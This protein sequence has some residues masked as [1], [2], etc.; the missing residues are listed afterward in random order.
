[1]RTI[2]FHIISQTARFSG[3]VTENKT[4][5]LIFSTT[6]VCNISLSRKSCRRYCHKS[7][8]LG[9]TGTRYFCR[10]LMKLQFSRQIC[11]KYSN[12]KFHE[13]SSSRS[14]VVPCERTDMTN[15]IGVFR[16]FAKAPRK[17]Q[18]VLQCNR[19]IFYL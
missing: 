5:V 7:T 8:I 9:F 15:L 4:R 17:Y 10:I 1:M 2:F 18:A 14:R 11:E 6:F 13:N 3:K 16:N 12:V 19:E